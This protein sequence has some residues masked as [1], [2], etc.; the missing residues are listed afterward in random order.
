MGKIV[1]IGLAGAGLALIAVALATKNNGGSGNSG[2]NG[3]GTD[4]NLTYTPQQFSQMANE[5]YL[6]KGYIDDDEATIY[7]NFEMLRTADDLANLIFVFGQK[8][9]IPYTAPMNLVEWVKDTLSVS[10][11]KR[12]IAV[13]QKFNYPY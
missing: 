8:T 1:A 3:N 7:K 10:E 9:F 11:Q 4:S 13:F 2:G 6:A 5:I 12:V